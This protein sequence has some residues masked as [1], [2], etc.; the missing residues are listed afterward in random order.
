MHGVQFKIGVLLL[1]FHAVVK[2]KLPKTRILPINCV[3]YFNAT[4]QVVGLLPYFYA[5]L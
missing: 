5:S 4:L 1:C 2:T 3:L